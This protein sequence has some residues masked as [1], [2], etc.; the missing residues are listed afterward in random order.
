VL[1][2]K[3]VSSSGESDVS[4]VKGKYVGIYFSA[5]WCGPCRN[6]TPKLA[7]TYKKIKAARSDFEIVFCS[8]DR[9]EEQFKEY[10]GTMPWLAL[11]FEDRDRADSLNEVR[12]L[13]AF[14]ANPSRIVTE[15]APY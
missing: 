2:S 8:A 7:E 14:F 10:F 9:D 3:F 11:P 6:F 12:V 4:A 1:G 13:Q 5:H 15:F